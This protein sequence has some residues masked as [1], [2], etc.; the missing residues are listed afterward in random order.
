MTVQ[1]LCDILQARLQASVQEVLGGEAV[2]PEDL[3]AVLTPEFLAGNVQALFDTLNNADGR[4]NALIGILESNAFLGSYQR[5]LT[6]SRS[7]RIDRWAQV[8][9]Q[10]NKQSS[11]GGVLDA[12]LRNIG[13]KVDDEFIT[14]VVLEGSNA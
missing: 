8:Y 6:Q 11:T 10:M 12:Q 9:S 14:D 7:G 5:M 13:V 1:G 3:S 4:E 2:S